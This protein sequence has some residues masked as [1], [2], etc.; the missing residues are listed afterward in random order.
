MMQNATS[1][2]LLSNVWTLK[3]APTTIDDLL[4][5][6]ENRQFFTSLTRLNNNLLFISSPGGGKTSTA[7]ILSKKFSPFSYIYINAS[8]ENGIDVVRTKISN[9]I[10]I[11]SFDGNP[12]VVILDEIDGA[13]T[14][15][16]QALRGVMEEYLNDVKF[17]LTGNFKHKILEAIQSRC[18]TF[19]FSLNIKDVFARMIYILK[20]EKITILEEDKKALAVLLKSH[21]PDI[22]KTINELQKCCVTGKFIPNIKKEETVSVTIVEKLKTKVSVWEI[23]KW[24][25]AHEQDFNNDYHFLMRKLFDHY[26]NEND[27][28]KVLLIVDTMHKHGIVADTEVNFTGLL[29]N[30]AK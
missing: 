21:F 25:L 2:Q 22:R 14:N 7:K 6:E 3:Y 18:Q 17:I 9:F 10:S 27:A 20:Q 5:S 1:E 12:K 26:V 29:I 15:F 16:Q 19:D 11:Q 23:R 4:L 8:E 30:L 24:V 13:T 28:G